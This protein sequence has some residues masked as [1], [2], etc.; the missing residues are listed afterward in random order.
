MV[1][2]HRRKLTSANACQVT[3]CSQIGIY[4]QAQKK[5]MAPRLHGSAAPRLPL[6]ILTPGIILARVFSDG[7]SQRDDGQ[8]LP[9]NFKR[10]IPRI[11]LSHAGV[12]RESGADKHM[13][14]KSLF[15]FCDEGRH[16]K[17]PHHHF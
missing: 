11:R 12:D 2:L 17:A 7:V 1:A 6:R 8:L 4:E 3:N 5:K 15:F 14:K 16:F 13:R 9:S 10:R